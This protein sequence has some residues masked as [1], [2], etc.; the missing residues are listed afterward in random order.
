VLVVVGGHARKVGKT[1]V[2]CG[3]IS[4]LRD[5]RWTAIKLTPHGHP[6]HVTSTTPDSERYLAAGAA[7]SLWLRTPAED[8][9][10]IL[11]ES[12]NVIIESNSVL[13]ILTPDFALMVLDARVPDFKASAHRFLERAD[14]LVVTSHAPNTVCDVSDKPVFEACPPLY[15]NSAL[16]TAIQLKS[17]ARR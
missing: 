3:I 14:A 13:D 15:S 11:S 1:A 16:V 5:W 9:P 10:R 12:E 8:L 6:E 7:R 4:G 2:I 17:L